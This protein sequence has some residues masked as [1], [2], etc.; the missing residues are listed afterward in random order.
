MQSLFDWADE[1]FTDAEDG[2]TDEDE[3]LAGV[4]G[5]GDAVNLSS[6]IPPVEP[7]RP[8]DSDDDQET[9]TEGDVES[10]GTVEIPL[11]RTRRRCP[12]VPQVPRP[13]VLKRSRCLNSRAETA[14][15]ACQLKAPERRF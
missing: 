5:E 4:E 2:I 8:G 1:V 9:S 3:S 15:L 6:E 14:L 12:E 13:G 11:E 7:E 10:Q